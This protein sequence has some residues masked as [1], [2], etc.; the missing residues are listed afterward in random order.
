MAAPPSATEPNA[1]PAN[2]MSSGDA[3]ELTTSSPRHQAH[4]WRAMPLTTWKSASEFPSPWILILR[5]VRSTAVVRHGADDL[6]FKERAEFFGSMPPSHSEPGRQGEGAKSLL[7]ED[8]SSEGD[9]AEGL[10]SGVAPPLKVDRL[11]SSVVVDGHVQR[12]AF[13]RQDKV[14]GYLV[15]TL[16]VPDASW[17]RQEPDWRKDSFC[18]RSG[19]RRADDVLIVGVKHANSAEQPAVDGRSSVVI[20]VGHRQEPSVARDLSAPAE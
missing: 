18:G 17:T 5:W 10:L 16:R 19:C 2:R 11:D 4:N 13:G 8:V 9:V 6:G 7:R 14:D 3:S 12:G 1:C 20:A 15:V